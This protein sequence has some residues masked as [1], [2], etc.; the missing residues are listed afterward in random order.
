MKRLIRTSAVISMDSARRVVAGGGILVNGNV[1][2]S[3]LDRKQLEALRDFHGETVEAGNLVALPGF[4]QTHIHLCQTLFR[5]LADDLELLDWLKLRIMPFEAA[6]SASS[7]RVSAMLGLAELIRSGTTTIMDMGSMNH[8]EEVIRAVDESG[9]RA[10]VG[11][12]M[13]DLNDLHPPL[14]ESTRDALASTLRYAEYAHGSADGRIK[15]AVA[16][17][18]ILSCTDG[19]LKEAYE[20]TKN[21]PGMLFHT[22]ASEN[23]NEIAAVRRRCNMDNIEYFGELDILH[24]NTCLAHCIWVTEKEEQL[25]KERRVKVLHCPSSNL[26]LGSGVARIPGFLGGGIT[27][28]LG[29][30]GA[31]CNNRL[32][33]FE[34]MRLAALLQ[35]PVHGPTSMP[36]ST[37]LEMATLGGAQ[38]LGLAAEIGSLEAGKK[39]DMIL[40]D[41]SRPWTPVEAK[42]E[43]DLYSSIVY[44]CTP[45]NVH[46]VMIDG[47]WVYRNYAH[48][49]LNEQS[50]TQQAKSELRALLGRLQ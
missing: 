43:S 3:V 23:R 7:M 39:A 19:L 32:D 46:S 20:M 31:P 2:E 33:M 13:M 26:K 16:P 21:F 6:H 44:S 11:K 36:A 34:E 9:M 45:E 30:D 47:R 22:H 10:F 15:Y 4:V 41:L 8:E 17:R 29:A 24:D 49:T 25:M 5:G 12:A 38:T 37:V 48:T 18:Y 14:R 28:S 42:S 27:V 50:T 1:I 35:K 40:L